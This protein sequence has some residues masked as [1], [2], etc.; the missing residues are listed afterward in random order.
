MMVSES[1]GGGTWTGMGSL[2]QA[3]PKIMKKNRTIQKIPSKLVESK[4]MEAL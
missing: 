3:E 4:S 2:E 1:V